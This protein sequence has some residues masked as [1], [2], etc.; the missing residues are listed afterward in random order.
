[1]TFPKQT[2]LVPVAM[3]TTFAHTACEMDERERPSECVRA[4][5]S[6]R[7]ISSWKA[8]ISDVT[9]SPEARESENLAGLNSRN[10]SF[11]NL[12]VDSGRASAS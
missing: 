9:A 6:S 1:M 5:S 3:E 7:G 10:W 12:S 8:C 4:S 11:Q 2:S